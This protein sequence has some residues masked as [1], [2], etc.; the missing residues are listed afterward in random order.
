MTR[1]LLRNP[2]PAAKVYLFTMVLGHSGRCYAELIARCELDA[3]L[4]FHGNA[5][6]FFGG[7]PGG[8]FYNTRENPGLRRL[9][10]GYPFHLP[11]VDCARHYGFTAHPTPAFAPWMKGRLKRPGKILQKLFF[12]GYAVRSL[13]QA[14]A[15]MREWM[16]HQDCFGERKPDSRPERLRSLPGTGF[17]PRDRRQHLRLRA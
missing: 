4:R 5:F 6:A 3:F 12:P 1:I 10:G 16:T 7:V 2:G 9:A 13:E 17:D 14:N 15:D 8:V 11:L